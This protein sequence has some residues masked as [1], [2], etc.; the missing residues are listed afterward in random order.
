LEKINKKDMKLIQGCIEIKIQSEHIDVERLK[1]EAELKEIERLKDPVQHMLDDPDVRNGVIGICV[2]PDIEEEEKIKRAE[3]V[4]AMRIANEIE[5]KRLEDERAREKDERDTMTLD[6][7]RAR[8]WAEL[9]YM[10]VEDEE[11]ET[12]EKVRSNWRKRC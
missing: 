2:F 9:Y 5:A 10:S 11:S 4:E 1:L 3:H 6:D 12:Y 7:E 8:E